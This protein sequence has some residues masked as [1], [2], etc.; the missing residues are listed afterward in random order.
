MKCECLFRYDMYSCKLIFIR[1]ILTFD[2]FDTFSSNFYQHHNF[3]N[4]LMS[5]PGKNDVTYRNRSCALL[6]VKM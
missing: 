6:L 2:K 3:H 1:N 5:L 4:H